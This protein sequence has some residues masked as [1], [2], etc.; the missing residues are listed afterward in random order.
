MSLHSEPIG[1]KEATQRNSVQISPIFSN[2]FSTKPQDKA[3]TTSHQRSNL[4]IQ[5]PGKVLIYNT[6]T[7]N[8]YPQNRET[9]EIYWRIPTT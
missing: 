3:R 2:M 9:A 4:K 5:K 7:V 8:F 6:R 1:N